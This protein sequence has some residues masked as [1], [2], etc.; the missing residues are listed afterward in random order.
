MQKYD[1]L[2]FDADNTLFDF[3][4]SEAWA[5][6]Q[7]IIGLGIHFIP[8]HIE[9]YREI[10]HVCWRQYENGKLKKEDL[11]ERRFELFFKKMNLSPDINRV[12]TDYLHNLSQSAIMIPGAEALLKKVS[13]NHTLVLVTNG[14]KEVQRPRLRQSTIEQYFEVIVVSDEIGYA[15]PAAAFFDYTF[16][17]IAY[18]DKSKVLMIGDNINADIKGGLSYGLDSCWYNPTQKEAEKGI[19]PT[20]IISEISQLLDLL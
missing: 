18:P 15:K 7:A 2:L 17:K 10:N 1:Y 11:R 9:I 12:A 20:Y 3:H 14:L 6:E 19:Q 5:L 13:E 4:A 8:E 16:N